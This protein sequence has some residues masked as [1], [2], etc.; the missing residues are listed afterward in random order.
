MTLK[1]AEERLTKIESLVQAVLLRIG[2]VEQKLE[3]VEFLRKEVEDTENR[4]AIHELSVEDKIKDVNSETDSRVVASELRCEEKIKVLGDKFIEAVDK[5][6]AIE[7]KVDKLSGDLPTPAEAAEAW[8]IATNKRNTARKLGRTNT[9]KPSHAEKFKDKSKDTIVLLGDSLTRGV[10]AKLEYQSNMVSTICRPGAHIDDIT[11]EVRKL[12]D[13]E[14]RHVV[15]LVGTNDIQREGSEV[16]LSKYKNL[17]DESQ[18]IK[19][20]KASV[21]GIPRRGDL[22]SFCNSRRLGVNKRLKEMCQG[23]NIEFLDYEP[24]DSWLARDG[25]HLN[26]LGQNELGFKI[27]QHCKSFLM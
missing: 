18:K 1:E 23:S 17:I 9:P 27:Y 21:V 22:D 2:V 24:R 5:L 19:N 20:R 4:Q 10:G 12:G 13:N 26:H 8:S 25:L 11:E 3:S 7:S 14:D 16:I 15:L 6:M